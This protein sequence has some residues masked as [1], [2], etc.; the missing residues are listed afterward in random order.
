MK[1]LVWTIAHC[2]VLFG[3]VNAALG[4][5]AG[6]TTATFADVDQ[7]RESEAANSD[8][9]A[10]QSN[11]TETPL[12][13]Y[14]RI[15]KITE[16][17]NDAD[18][19]VIQRLRFS[20]RYQQDYATV[21]ADQG[22]ASEWNVR[23]LRLGLRATLFKAVT[24]HTEA[25]LNPQ[26]AD[27]VFVRLTDAYV[28]W[29]ARD[30][31]AV[32]IGKQGVSFTLD[33][34][35]S[36]KEL[37]AMERSNL[38]NNIWFSEEYLPGLNVA[39]SSAPWV[40]QAGLYSAGEKNREFGEFTGG[41]VGLGTIGYDFAESMGAKQALLTLNYVYQDPDPRNTFTQPLQHV[42]SLN[43]R[44]ETDEWGFQSDM[45]AAAGYFDQSDIYGVMV[46]PFINATQKLQ[47]V[48]RYTFLTSPGENGI[49]VATY[50]DR[51]VSG[52]GDL[53]HDVYLGANYYF[54]GHQLKL[55]TG[56]QF[57]NMKDAAGDGGAYSG[58]SWTVGLR[59][60]W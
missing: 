17:Y 18:N 39:V 52:R 2:I 33:G 48:G 50:E 9:A 12:S 27:P 40:Y 47:F 56:V 3:P 41:L 53:Y 25:D 7:A 49:E 26:E 60:G 23:R 14:D 32:T 16:W 19:P 35:T 42:V 5:T 29:S 58:V 28:E 21:A 45:S 51:V 4:Q 10:G 57:A 46:M 44:F 55:Q 11:T 38:A 59:V 1:G 31:V 36:S 6:I 30:Q 24:V 13:V 8:S 37:L 54:Y 15:W 20:G 34:T 43:F 22:D